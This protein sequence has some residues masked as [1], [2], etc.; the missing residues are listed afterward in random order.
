MECT[1]L[2]GNMI[3]ETAQR[4]TN[5]LSKTSGGFVISARNKSFIESK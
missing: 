2:H 1:L 4:Q 5:I 3:K